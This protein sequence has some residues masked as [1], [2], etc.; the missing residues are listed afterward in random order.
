MH[1]RCTVGHLVDDGALHRPGDACCAPDAPVRA[2]LPPTGGPRTQLGE[3][4]DRVIQIR[5]LVLGD[6]GQHSTA[7]IVGEEGL[8]G[9][10][11]DRLAL[12]ATVRR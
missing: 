5:E 1:A 10:P 4:A 3:A 6:L 2:L 12:G 9:T 11:I 7:T 8:T